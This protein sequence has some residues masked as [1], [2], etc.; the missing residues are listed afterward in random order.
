MAAAFCEAEDIHLLRSLSLMGLLC[1][2]RTMVCRLFTG[3]DCEACCGTS[4]GWP[5]RRCIRAFNSTHVICSRGTKG[6][7]C[8]VQDMDPDSDEREA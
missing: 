7:S 1:G 3:D 8:E 4:P 2:A 6:E 5:T